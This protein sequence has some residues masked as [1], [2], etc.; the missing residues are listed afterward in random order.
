MHLQIRM[1]YYV[2][3]MQPTS[4]NHFFIS[5]TVTIITIATIL[6]QGQSSESLQL[7]Q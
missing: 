5:I 1:E 6:L 3:V 4:C 2:Q 7:C